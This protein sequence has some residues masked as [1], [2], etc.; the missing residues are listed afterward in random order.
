[1]V[2]AIA[3]AA[4]LCYGIAI[5]LQ[6]GTAARADPAASLRLRLIGDLVRRPV[7]VLGIAAN[8]AGYGLRFLALSRGSLVL[9]QPLLVCG[10]LF[11]LPLGAALAGRPLQTR[12]W[13]GACAIVVGLAAFLVAAGPD[14]G[15]E[16]ASLGAWAGLALVLGVPVAGLVAGSR[17][18]TATRAASMLA[19]AAGALFAVAAALTKTAASELRDGIGHLVAS[20][21][22]YAVVAVGLLGM[23]VIQS[24]FQA[25]P[26]IASMPVLIVV[27]P[28]ASIGIGR[29]LLGEHLASSPAGVAVEVVGLALMSVGVVVACASPVLGG[30]Q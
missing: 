14:K 3:L 28:L 15:R 22:P 16:T 18:V 17:R 29:A 27:E 25:G 26:L 30:A 2:A 23:V 7:W 10:L 5:V 4:S 6:H 21:V 19:A 20:P 13:A 9:V 1:M 8:L 11:A 12:E 24:A